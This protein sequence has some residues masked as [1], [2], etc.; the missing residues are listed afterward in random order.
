MSFHAIVQYLQ[1]RWRA[2]GRHGTHSPFVYRFVEEVLRKKNGSLEDR[3]L[4]YTVS[5]N[6]LDEN[7]V[8]SAAQDS[9]VLVRHPHATHKSTARWNAI[10]ARPEVTLSIDLYNIG[11]LFFRKEFKVKQHFIL[12]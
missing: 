3:I 10:R 1:Y 7:A 9:I 6:F 11:L 8:E 2:Q 12:K 4:R 5:E